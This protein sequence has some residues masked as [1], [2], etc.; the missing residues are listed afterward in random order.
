MRIAAITLLLA[1]CHAMYGE[2]YRIPSEAPGIS[3]VHIQLEQP[4]RSV[5]GQFRTYV[6]VW[7][8][9]DSGE[10]HVTLREADRCSAVLPAPL[11]RG[12]TY[13][14]SDGQ[15][16]AL[17]VV[18][19]I[20]EVSGGRYIVTVHERDDASSHVVACASVP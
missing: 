13:A 16:I 2:A 7:L 19:R 14:T 5:T 20:E 18:G 8:E 4:R 11:V 9:G 15:F 6:N 3:A 17:E 10:R 12:N 1:G